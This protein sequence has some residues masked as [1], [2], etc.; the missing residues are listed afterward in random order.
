[1]LAE[2]AEIKEGC[3]KLEINTP[4]SVCADG[5][6]MDVLGSDCTGSEECTQGLI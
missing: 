5:A 3:W 4:S 2:L 1:M 6:M